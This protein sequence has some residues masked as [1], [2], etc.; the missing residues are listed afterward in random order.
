M[1]LN[2]LY[3]QNKPTISFE[4]FPPDSDESTEK[5]YEEIRKLQTY[6]PDFISITCGAGGKGNNTS[7][8]ILKTLKENFSVDIMPHFTCMCSSREFIDENLEFLKSLGTENILALRGDKPKDGE[9]A[10]KDF[11]YA[12]ELVKYLKEKTDFS[13]AAAG[14]PEGHIEA[15]S[16]EEDIKNLKKKIDA[17]ADVIFTQLF[18]E[19]EKFYTYCEKVQQA[20]ISTP[21]IAGI[22]PILSLKQLNKMTNLARVSIPKNLFEQIEKHENDKNYIKNLGI[23]FASRQCRDLLDNG[24]K[25]L[26]FFTLNKAYSTTQI[27][28]NIQ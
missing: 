28:K 6:N 15:P 24:V 14:Y 13:I 20:G 2:E 8:K 4:V 9:I 3:K 21:V 23:E 19:N 10:C 16:L 1:K 18:F 22:M 17:G 5:L 12:S 11:C 7:K 27:L 26:H 25:G